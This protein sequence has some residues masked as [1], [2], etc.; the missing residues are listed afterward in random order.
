VQQPNTESAAVVPDVSQPSTSQVPVRAATAQA[1]QGALSTAV[2][3]EPGTPAFNGEHAPY[4][5]KLLQNMAMLIM[6]FTI[7][8]A[9]LA[10]ARDH[11]ELWKDPEYRK[12]VLAEVRPKFE[13]VY[14][15]VAQ[16]LGLS[17]KETESLFDLMTDN[18]ITREKIPVPKLILGGPT[19]AELI[20]RR[21]VDRRT[22]EILQANNRRE[23][24]SIQ[25]LLGD[26]YMQWQAYR[27]RTLRI[28]S[29]EDGLKMEER[30]RRNRA[31]ARPLSVTA[32]RAQVAARRESEEGLERIAAQN[33]RMRME[34]ERDGLLPQPPQE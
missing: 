10:Y 2:K 5:A 7:E 29:F 26:K 17:E 34:L 22:M 30:M 6:G 16:E 28:R 27:S 11:Q 20:E 9:K 14:P 3:T 1:P 31:E 23:D 24:E 19:P 4:D 21:D 25:A 13:R 8:D 18:A 33:R 32:D 15:G 12:L